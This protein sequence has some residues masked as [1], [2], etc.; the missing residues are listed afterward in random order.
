M[1]T[2]THTQTH[3]ERKRERMIARLIDEGTNAESLCLS[4]SLSFLTFA[5]ALF[6]S[7]AVFD[8]QTLQKKMRDDFLFRV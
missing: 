3:R 5:R 4:L 2:H 1:H 6:F 7:L 8:V